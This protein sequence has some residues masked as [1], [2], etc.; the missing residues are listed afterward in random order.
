MRAPLGNAWIIRA[1]ALSTLLLTLAIGMPVTSTAKAR[2]KIGSLMLSS[3]DLQVG[4]PFPKEFILNGF[5]CTGENISPR[6]VWRGVPK[7]T[8][9]FVITLFDRDEHGTPSGWWHWVL[10]DIPATADRLEKNAGTEGSKALPSGA[11]QGRNDDSR[12][13]YAG[14]CPDEGDAPH[15]YIWT[16]YALS[17]AILPVPAEASGA[18][19]TYTAHQYTLGTAQLIS[20]YGRVKTLHHR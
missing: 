3:P 2:H 16:L 13:A 10:Y 1:C 12:D 9:S 17:V 19:V 14:P 15:H 7:D 20:L 18:N 4:K 8:K 11:R 5:G 6:L